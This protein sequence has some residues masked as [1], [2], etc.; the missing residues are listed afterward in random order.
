MGNGEWGMGNGEWGMGNGEWGMGNGEWGIIEQVSPL[1]LVSSLF[2]MPYP[3]CPIPNALKDS[4][5][6][7]DLNQLKAVIFNYGIC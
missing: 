6:S 7:F 3:Q 5:L 2:P 1:S 4:R